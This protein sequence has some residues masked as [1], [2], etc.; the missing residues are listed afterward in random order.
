MPTP[1]LNARVDPETVAKLDALAAERGAT[2][3][4]LVR[5]ALALILSDAKAKETRAP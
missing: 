4:D 3:S 5:E 2:R 1:L